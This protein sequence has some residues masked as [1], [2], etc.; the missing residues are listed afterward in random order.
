MTWIGKTWG[1][2][3]FK[4]WKTHI[5]IYLMFVEGWYSFCILS[6]GVICV[7]LSFEFELKKMAGGLV[8]AAEEYQ[9]TH[10]WPRESINSA[11]YFEFDHVVTIWNTAWGAQFFGRSEGEENQVTLRIRNGC[12]GSGV[13]STCFEALKRGINRR[14]AWETA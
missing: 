11:V 5:T 14:S 8:T 12:H 6:M 9:A 7:Q 10:V 2:C 1:V 4:G 13:K 3:S